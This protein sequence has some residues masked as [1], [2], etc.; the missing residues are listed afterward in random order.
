VIVNQ[1][2][3][4]SAGGALEYISDRERQGH[5]NAVLFATNLAVFT[6]EQQRRIFDAVAALRPG[7][8]RPAFHQ[9]ISF[10]TDERSFLDTEAARSLPGLLLKGL[11]ADHAPRVA[12]RHDEGIHV[13]S[14]LVGWSGEAISVW[15]SGTRAAAVLNSLAPQFGLSP[16]QS[17]NSGPPRPRLSRGELE[18]SESAIEQGQDPSPK[19]LLAA[20]MNY[21][22]ACCS[23][24]DDEE[25]ARHLR[26]MRVQTAWHYDARGAVDGVRFSLEDYRGTCC[27]SLKGSQIGEAFS[28][29]RLRARLQARAEDRYEYDPLDLFAPRTRATG[30]TEWQERYDRLWQVAQRGI[31]R[32]LPHAAAIP[33]AVQSE[34]RDEQPFHPPAA[35]LWESDQYRWELPRNTHPLPQVVTISLPS[36]RGGDGNHG[37]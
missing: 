24:G 18:A 4:S 27:S 7:I 26:S 11:S 5:K 28:Y 17:D 16:V 2:C 8:S 32:L 25:F 33:H 29:P 30:A 15:R 34:P 23:G 22:I 35:E 10:L 12:W 1:T 36:Q 9:S 20:R 13:V 21:A 6:V 14:S 3:G 19:L 37:R 31:E